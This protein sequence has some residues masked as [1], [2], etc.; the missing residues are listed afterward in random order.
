[1]IEDFIPNKSYNIV[2]QKP[3]WLTY[4]I[5]PMNQLLCFLLY[6]QPILSVAVSKILFVG[7][8]Q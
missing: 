7:K 5:N 4:N 2:N 3:Q 1:M 8:I 6:K